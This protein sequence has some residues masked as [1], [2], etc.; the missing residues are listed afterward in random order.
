MTKRCDRSSSANR[1]T[2]ARGN[3]KLFSFFFFSFA[4]FVLRSRCQS[5][6]LHEA[7]SFL[8]PIMFYCPGSL[9]LS[10]P[11]TV[12]LHFGLIT[13][14][15]LISERSSDRS[16]G[17][18]SASLF[19][20]VYN[21]YPSFLKRRE[22]SRCDKKRLSLH[23]TT[24]TAA[25]VIVKLLQADKSLELCISATTR[26]DRSAERVAAFL[27]NREIFVTVRRFVNGVASSIMSRPREYQPPVLAYSH[28]ASRR[29][30]T[31]AGPRFSP[32]ALHSMR[33]SRPSHLER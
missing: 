17:K 33:F 15:S 12:S 4:P 26:F 25:T 6:S 23:R 14:R 22:L 19:L 1:L 21:L 11:E 3:R 8:D 10:S 2:T 16:I 5:A 9:F 31:N 13:D 29:S 30:P 24:F 20:L 32:C 27:L 18:R 7:S 28:R